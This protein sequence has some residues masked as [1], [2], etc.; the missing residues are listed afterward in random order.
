[1]CTFAHKGEYK[2]EDQK[3]VIRSAR[4]KWIAP[5]KCHKIFFVHWSGQVP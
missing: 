2:R 5:N 3:M 1:M 4:T